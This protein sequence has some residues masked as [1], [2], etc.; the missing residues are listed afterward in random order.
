M[1]KHM[2]L[3][4]PLVC[5]LLMTGCKSKEK[6]DL[7]GI[8]TTEAQ[9][10][11][12]ESLADPSAESTKAPDS[13]M[14]AD[15]NTAPSV[16]ANM[17]TYTNNKVSIQYPVVSN[18]SDSAIQE[19]VN[20]LLKANALRAIEGL[21][22]DESKDTISVKAQVVSINRRRITVTYE[23][24]FNADGAAHPVNLFYSNTVDMES[25]GNLGLSDYADPYTVAGYIA[26]GDYKFAEGTKVSESD[27]RAGL[28]GTVE[29]YYEMLKKADFTGTTE[30]FPEVFS[31]EKQ[32]TIYISPPV[33]HALGDYA[34]IVYSPD[35]K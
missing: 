35:N 31:Y 16:A 32:G 27:L 13:S 2:K 20:A 24:T 14:E 21:G 9:T 4:L 7:S 34:L 22:A 12:R 1:R 26:S 17:E 33:V 15:K 25:A 19:E 30:G 23:G 18:L 5:S 10:V 3:L 11:E 8:H 28:K 29:S 6:I